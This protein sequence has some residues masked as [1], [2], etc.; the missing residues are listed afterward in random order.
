MLKFFLNFLILLQ[1]FFKQLKLQLVFPLQSSV[2]G[3]GFH[4]LLL[5]NLSLLGR[6]VWRLTQFKDTLYYKVLS[7]KYFP[8]GNIFWPKEVDKPSYTWSG[9]FKAAKALQ[10]GFVWFVGDGKSIDIRNDNW[11]FKGLNGDSLHHSLLSDNERVLL[12][13][14]IGFDPHR[15]YWRII[16]KLKLLPNIRVFS[17]RKCP[18]CKANEETLIYALKDCLSARAILT[19]EGLDNRLIEG[20]C[21]RC[22]NWLEDVLRVIDLKNS[23]NNRNNF[24]FKGR[25]DDAHVVWERAKSFS[26]DFRIHNLVELSAIP[27]TTICKTWTKPLNDYVK[28]NFDGSVSNG[29]VGFG[30]HKRFG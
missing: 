5:F 26:Q 11:G 7:S 6:Q 12:F 2:G 9:I 21:S 28:I 8:N 24:V 19:L 14:N 10:N 4:D 17:W 20:N 22:I 15:A 29:K 18:R 27:A 25:E 1:M 30:Y 3:L 13:K 16:W 23:W